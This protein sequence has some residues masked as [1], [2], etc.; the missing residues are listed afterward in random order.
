VTWVQGLSSLSAEEKER[1]LWR[2]LE[3]LLGL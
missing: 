1:I 2:N 3:T